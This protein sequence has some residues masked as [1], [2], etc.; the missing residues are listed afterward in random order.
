MPVGIHYVGPH[1]GNEIIEVVTLV[2]RRRGGAPIAATWPQP[3]AVTRRD[4]RGRCG[5]DPAD[6]TN[7]VINRGCNGDGDE[8]ARRSAS[9][10][11]GVEVEERAAVAAGAAD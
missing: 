1:Q 3:A 5:A 9:A 7:A 8:Y 4:F 2:L 11:S 10:G 6:I